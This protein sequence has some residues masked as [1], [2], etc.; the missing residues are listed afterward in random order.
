MKVAFRKHELSYRNIRV[1]Y[2]TIKQHS[3]KCFNLNGFSIRHQCASAAFCYV[4]GRRLIE[5]NIKY[6]KYKLD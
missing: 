5:L 4:H 1:S 3:P 2:F 6:S